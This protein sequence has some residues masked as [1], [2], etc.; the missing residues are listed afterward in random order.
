[1]PGTDEGKEGTRGVY[2]ADSHTIISKHNNM[3]AGTEG[4]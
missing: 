1:V 3:A 4:R 2:A